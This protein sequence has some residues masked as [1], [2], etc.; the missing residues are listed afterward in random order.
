MTVNRALRPLCILALACAAAALPRV[1]AGEPAASEFPDAWYY[2]GQ[3]RPPA[4]RQLESKPAPVLTVKDWIGEPRRLEDLAGKVVIVDFWATWCGPCM[5]ALPKNIELQE[6]YRDCGVVF[7]GVHDGRRGHERM[8]S[9]AERQKINYSLSVDQDGRSA[10]AWH[11]SFWPTYFV[12]DQSGIVRAAGLQPANVKNVI[13]QLLEAGPHTASPDS[14][15][16]PAPTPPPTPGSPGTPGSPETSPGTSP[17]TAPG[18]A[19]AHSP[20]VSPS[21]AGGAARSGEW[22]ERGIESRARLDHLMA[23]PRAPELAVA[24]WVGSAPM[25]LADL[26]GKVVLLD[27]WGVWCGACRASIARTNGWLE[28]FGPEGLVVIGVCHA[29]DVDRMKTRVK[30]W[31]IRFPACADSK[32][33]TVST[34]AVDGFPDYYLIDR[35]G[36]V[37]FADCADHAVEDAIRLLLKEPAAPPVE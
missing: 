14:A 19:P 33:D 24:D 16:P 36:R 37:R 29:R 34:Y 27:F 6:Q 5:K 7:L 31:G 32:N 25:R 17:G 1:T 3:G 12:L 8:A 11:V 26:T 28:T 22:M 35:R 18:T 13:D 20:A 10:A 15:A 30:E 21:S 23:L 4:L 9:V 2:F